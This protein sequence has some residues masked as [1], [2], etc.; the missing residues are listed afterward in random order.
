MSLINFVLQPVC[1][2]FQRIEVK[3]FS[4]NIPQ[5]LVFLPKML[6]INWVSLD[7]NVQAGVEPGSFRAVDISS[8]YSVQTT[9]LGCLCYL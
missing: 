1:S 5:R 7:K 9:R 8:L 6:I 3:Q 4:L 2:T